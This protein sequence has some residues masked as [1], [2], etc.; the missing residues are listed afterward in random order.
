M[1]HG[2]TL[3]NV[4]N[5]KLRRFRDVFGAEWRNDQR[6]ARMLAKMLKLRNYLD[7]DQEKAFVVVEKST[8]V[9]EKLKILSRHQRT[10]I[11]EK[12]R[13]QNRLRKRLLEV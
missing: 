9:N 3:Y 1:E 13:L 8:E 10:L 12:I 7:S 6:D 4:D 11:N 5:L 2:F